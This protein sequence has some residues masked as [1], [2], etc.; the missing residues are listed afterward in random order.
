MKKFRLE[1]TEAEEALV[2]KIDLRLRHA[3]HDEGRAAYLANQG[4][5]LGLLRL[6]S[7]RGAVPEQRISYWNDPAYKP[8][9]V[10]GSR[11]QM[12]ERNG[13]HGEDIYTHPHFIEHLRYIL[14]GTDLPDAVVEA[15]ETE[16]GD[17]RW[18]S[19]GDALDLGKKA[20][21]LVRSHALEPAWAGDEF[22]KLAVDLGLGLDRALRIR[23]TVKETR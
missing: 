20:R 4:P 13:C 10:K 23:T 19:Y 11:K 21:A 7:A 17:P 16:V 15:F 6:L 3:N 14:L 22:F 1:L 18:V 8:G 5:I 12:F 2:A 9:R